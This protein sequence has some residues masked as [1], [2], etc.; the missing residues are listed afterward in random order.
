MCLCGQGAGVSGAEGEGATLER[1]AGGWQHQTPPVKGAPRPRELLAK[2]GQGEIT[3]FPK[4]EQ[5]TLGHPNNSGFPS[6]F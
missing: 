4:G 3:A 6:E 5:Q 1:W 2:Q